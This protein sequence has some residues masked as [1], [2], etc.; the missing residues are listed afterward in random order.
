MS[1]L[2]GSYYPKH[3]EFFNSIK[4]VTLLVKNLPW[5]VYYSYIYC[6]HSSIVDFMGHLALDLGHN[7]NMNDLSEAV[8]AKFAAEPCKGMYVTI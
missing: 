2:T 6:K 7:M 3:P 4:R 1:F 5:S 8:W